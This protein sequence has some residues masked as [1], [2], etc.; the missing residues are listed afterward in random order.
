MHFRRP[1]VTLL[2]VALA[3]LPACNPFA[4]NLT[5]SSSSSPSSANGRCISA[6][7]GNGSTLSVCTQS[8]PNGACDG[9]SYE[10]GTETFACATCSDCS[11]AAAL[12]SQACTNASADAG[13]GTT[14]P[15]GSTGGGSTTCTANQPCGTSGASYEECTSTSANGACTSVDFVTS[16]GQTFTC[17]GCSDCTQAAQDLTSYCSASAGGGGGGG[18]CGGVP[19]GSAATCCTCSGQPSC[20]TLQSGVTCASYGCN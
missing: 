11:Q 17:N 2:A 4:H 1:P 8:A 14:N 20:L 19:C 9:I 18:Q 7:C 5:E 6:P 10:V 16:D 12:A 15:F 3:L 13:G